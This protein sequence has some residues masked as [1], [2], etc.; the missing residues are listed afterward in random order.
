MGGSVEQALFAMIMLRPLAK[1]ELS[2]K[3]G[4][5]ERALYSLTRERDIQMMKK[6]HKKWPN[7]VGFTP[8][9]SRFLRSS[10]WQGEGQD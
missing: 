1:C 7:L 3:K 8:D 6:L 9:P 5:G 4:C 10:C 2:L